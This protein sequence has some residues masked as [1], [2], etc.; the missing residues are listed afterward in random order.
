VSGPERFDYE[1]ALWGQETIR[2]DE[3]SIA[4][5]RLAEVL[6]SLPSRGR[7]LEVGCGAGRF[8]CALESLR[9]DLERVG[10]DLSARALA[11]LAA[12]S[13][14]TRTRQVDARSSTL[15]AEDGEFDAV[16]ALDVLEHVPD[17]DAMLSE[18]RRVLKPRAAF[19]LHVPCEASPLC[20]W[21]WIPGQAGPEGLKRRYAGHIQRFTRNALIRRVAD[22]GFEVDRV[23]NSLHLLGNLAD[24]AAFVSIDRAHRSN[25]DR[26]PETTGD[27]LA[28][29]AGGKTPAARLIRFVD[30]LLWWEARIL[31][32]VPSWS[33]HV[34][35]RR[36]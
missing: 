7:V 13:P 24:V 3:R 21:R 5:F 9:P 30:Q 28:A 12:R 29:S 18:I 32:A 14:E 36:L 17:P 23:R 26:P 25:P 19:H 31:A 34:S 8:L 2:P 20:V 1:G 33:L 35:A 15:P 11:A 10:A 16:L 6:A 27:L 22:A 4:G